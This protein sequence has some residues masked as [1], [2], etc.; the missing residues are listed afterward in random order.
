M[1]AS[2][3]ISVEAGALGGGTWAGGWGR[4]GRRLELFVAFLGAGA[5]TLPCV[6][7]HG[8]GKRACKQC[9]A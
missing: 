9:V 3:G 2:E 7:M 5:A 1:T 6:W 8:S 4:I